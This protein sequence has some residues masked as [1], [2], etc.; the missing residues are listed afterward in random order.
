MTPSPSGRELGAAALLA[1]PLALLF[2]WT[3]VFPL[4]GIPVLGTDYGQLV[5]NMWSVERAMSSGTSPLHSDIVFHP[6]GTSLAAHVLTPAFFPVTAAI[7][8]GR[9]LVGAGGEED[10]LYPLIAYKVAIGLC[11]VAIA[12]SAYAFLRRIGAGVL[13]SIAVTIAYAFSPFNQLHAPHLN[14]LAVAA[15]LPLAGSCLV[16]LWDRP[17]PGP[18][19]VVAFL[20]GGGPYFGELIAF[21]WVA[22]LVIGAI[23]L[24]RPGT[25]AEVLSRLGRIGAPRIGLALA[26]AVVLVSPFALAWVQGGAQPMNPRQA[27][28]WSAN[29]AAFVTP[30]PQT[31]PWLSFMAPLARRISKGVG[32]HEAFLGYVLFGSAILGLIRIRDF[33]TRLCGLMAFGFLVLSLGPSLKI[34]GSD[35][36]IAMPYS[37]LMSVP[38]FSM[39]RTPV[40]CVLFALFFLSVPAARFL[41]RVERKGARGAA[42]VAL[43]AVAAGF[44]MW[45]PRPLAKRFVSP[46]D[47]TRLVPGDVCNIPLTT[48]DGFAV[49][50]QTQHRRKIVTG[51]VSR[52]SKALADHVNGLGDLLDHQPEKFA[53]TLLSWGVTNVILEPGA[54]DGLEVSLPKLGLNVI[55]LRRSEGRIQ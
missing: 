4:D 5:W 21:A 38:P 16:S 33:W 39:G 46:L 31:Q 18:V 37:F 25:R 26:L 20:F 27:W 45:S 15:I 40:R 13:A 12:L 41:S 48:L 34:F 44:E 49:L 35:L 54:P 30:D 9:R 47:L 36:G 51:L 19:L 50:L 32:G 22:F 28:F 43:L 52:R 17:R 11:Y 24:A 8:L 14:H 55:D 6:V 2:T 23:L 42:L 10:L 7:K 1:V 3:Q 29:L 53:S